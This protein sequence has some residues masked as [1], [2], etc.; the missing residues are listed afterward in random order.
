[1]TTPHRGFPRALLEESLPSRLQYFRTLTVAHPHLVQAN[2]KL[3]EAILESPPN[4]VVLVYGPTGVGK[5]TLCVKVQQMLTNRF[6]SDLP[7]DAGRIPVVSV[8]A[9]APE[10]GNFSWKD[11]F[12]RLLSQMDEPLI[13]YKIA[14]AGGQEHTTYQRFTPAAKAVGSE[15]RYAV[16]Q[17]LCFRSP[18]AVLIDEAQHLA[19]MASGRQLLDQLDVI[20]SIANRSSTV[21]VLFGTYELLA[22]RNLSGQLSRRSIDLHFRRYLADDD[23]ERQIFVNVLRSFEQHLPFPEPP[24]LAKHWEFLYERSVGCIGILKEWLTKALSAALRNDETSL[25]LRHLE[26]HA[27]SVAQCQKV[28]SEIVEGERRLTET[29]EGRASL[30]MHLGL[31]RSSIERV[32]PSKAAGETDSRASVSTERRTARRPGVRLPVRDAIGK[33]EFANVGD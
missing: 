13:K 30:R 32:D 33:P 19:K 23:K 7:K 10:S 14:A 25:S 2:E 3:L 12:K 20:K 11:H 16:E 18:L 31:P 22:F 6:L 8:E 17:A 26:D 21:H 9:V 1:M 4:S 24:E 29:A 15:Y 5:T 27:A 28:L